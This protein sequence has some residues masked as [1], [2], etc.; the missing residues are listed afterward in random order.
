[1]IHILQQIRLGVEINVT[2]YV[3][4]IA[5]YQQEAGP[6]TKN[7]PDSQP[8]YVFGHYEVCRVYRPTALFIIPNVHKTIHLLERKYKGA[9]FDADIDRIFPCDHFNMFSNPQA[10]H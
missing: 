8:K 6:H 7:N 10:L 4:K 9:K 1:M 2:I 3:W 5:V